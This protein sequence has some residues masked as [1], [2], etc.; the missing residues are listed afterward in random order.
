MIGVREY[1]EF[2]EL[3]PSNI[4]ILSNIYELSHGLPLF[5]CLFF[6][7]FFYNTKHTKQPKQPKH[8]G[9]KLAIRTKK[10]TKPSSVQNIKLTKR[11]GGGFQLEW[12]EPVDGGGKPL[13]SYRIRAIPT[14]MYSNQADEMERNVLYTDNYLINQSPTEQC[15]KTN[16]LSSWQNCKH[17]KHVEVI[18]GLSPYVEYRLD[19]VAIS[20]ARCVVL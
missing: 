10:P 5:F 9:T 2:F 8:T 19:I 6:F 3:V 7:L 1:Y 18:G 15:R 20:S 13:V 11:T 4:Y 16:D 12:N 17:G 14:E